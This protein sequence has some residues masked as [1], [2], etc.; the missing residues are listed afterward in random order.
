MA[1]GDANGRES[2]DKTFYSRLQFRDYTHNSGK[3]IA[4]YF[5]A[6]MLK[7]TIQKDKGTGFEYDDVVSSYIPQSKAKI[8]HKELVNFYDLLKAGKIKDTKT[9][10]AI[11]TGMGDNQTI[12]CIHLSENG[13]PSLFI[14]KVDPS[15]NYL[16]HDD[17]EFNSPEFAFSLKISDLEKLKYSNENYENLELEQL[18][19]LMNNFAN[20]MDGAI[21][22]STNDMNRYEWGS[23][24]NKLNA[25]G[26]KN[27]L[28]F[29]VS[30]GGGFNRNSG[31]G[32]FSNNNNRPSTSNHTNIDS[33]SSKYSLDDEE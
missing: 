16:E 20:N 5:W 10:Y 2:K 13:N 4:V 15:G 8:F 25:I 6:G 3:R 19:N 33:I 22:Y 18:I 11:N 14:G 28:D 23:M 21:A 32:F 31:N 24:I 12:T 30:R 17:Y 9:G 27:G 7:L 1:L 29:G 26:E